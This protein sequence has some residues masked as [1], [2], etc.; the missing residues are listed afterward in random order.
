ITYF[1]IIFLRHW[2]KYY[3]FKY[4]PVGIIETS[5]IFASFKTCKSMFMNLIVYLFTVE[6]RGGYRA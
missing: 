6:I 4:C 2:K 1:S 5:S 3:R